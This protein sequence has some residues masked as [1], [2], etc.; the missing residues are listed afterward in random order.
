MLQEHVGVVISALAKGVLRIADIG[1]RITRK[2]MLKTFE[3]PL[4]YPKGSHSTILYGM[5]SL[6]VNNLE[7][8]ADLEHADIH[9]ILYMGC[10]I[11]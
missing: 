5:R 4:Q 10:S 1:E 3:Y 11:R 8:V 9:S 2:K 7:A 6:K